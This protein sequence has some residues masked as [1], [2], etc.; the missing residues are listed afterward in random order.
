MPTPPGAQ[1]AHHVF[2]WLNDPD[3]IA[4]RDAL[5]EG[6]RALAAIPAVRA[7]HVGVPASVEP[8]PVVDSSYSVSE[9]L[10][11]DTIEDQNTY[12]AH[13]LH[14]AFIARCRRSSCLRSA[15]TPSRASPGRNTRRC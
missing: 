10:F 6:V 1:L 8:R 9:L 15:G 5:I 11:F 7:L 12:Q 4:D 3:S 13:P 2:F 14:Q